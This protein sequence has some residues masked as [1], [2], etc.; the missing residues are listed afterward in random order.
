MWQACKLTP[1]RTQVS[2]QCERTSF[3]ASFA[4][5]AGKKDITHTMSGTVYFGIV[6]VRGKGGRGKGA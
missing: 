1:T 5:S 6:K 3:L 4:S 2:I